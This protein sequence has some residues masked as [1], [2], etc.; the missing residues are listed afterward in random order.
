MMLKAHLFVVSVA[1]ISLQYNGMLIWRWEDGGDGEAFGRREFLTKCNGYVD[2]YGFMSC[3]GFL[4][5][6]LSDC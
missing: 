4:C 2:M 3:G 6:F 5:P 1:D